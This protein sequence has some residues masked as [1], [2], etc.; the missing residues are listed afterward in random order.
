LFNRS[1]LF[2]ASQ[3]ACLSQV[4]VENSVIE[5]EKGD[6]VVPQHFWSELFLD[7]MSS[8]LVPHKKHFIE[9]QKGVKKYVLRNARLNSSVKNYIGLLSTGPLVII[10]SNNNM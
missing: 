9:G 4:A 10:R 2:W 7:S 6:S 8:S 5:G 3:E 1:E